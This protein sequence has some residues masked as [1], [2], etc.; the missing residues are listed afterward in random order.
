[1]VLPANGAHGSVEGTFKAPENLWESIPC[2]LDSKADSTF[3]LADAVRL[4][5]DDLSRVS[6]SL[7][8]PTSLPSQ[9]ID[10]RISE[11]EKQQLEENIV[12]IE[13]ELNTL[14]DYLKLCDI[15]RREA[16]NKLLDLK[17]SIRVFCRLRPFHGNEKRARPGP[18][19]APQSDQVVVKA[20]GKL[21]AY[22]FDKVFLPEDSQDDVFAELVPILRSALDGHNVCIF[23]YGQTGTGK[24]YTME[25][26]PDSPGVVPHTFKELFRQAALDSSLTFT[27][28]ISMLEV[29]KGSL[30]DLLVR[31]PTRPT[32]TSA[33]CLSIQMDAPSG[34]EI[35][36][37]HEVVVMDFKQA[38]QLYRL[39]RRARST[40]WTN[41]NEASSR[42]HSLIRIVIRGSRA[43][44]AYTI[45]SKL[46]MVDLGGSERILKTRASGQTMEEA[47]AINLSLSALGDVINALQRKQPHIPYRNSKLTQILK[48]SLAN[49]S[50]VVMLL[51]ISPR[52]D[53]LSETVCS[54]SFGTRARGTQLG[55]EL[56]AEAKEQRT[57][58]MAD[59]MLHMR[60]L[61]DECHR[62]I[63]HIQ[64]VELLLREKKKVLKS[65][66]SENQMTQT[67]ASQEQ[68]AIDTESADSCSIV[69]RSIELNMPRFM[70]PTACSRL[71]GRAQD[72]NCIFPGKEIKREER[73]GRRLSLP[74]DARAMPTC[75]KAS[76]IRQSQRNSDFN[77]NKTLKYSMANNKVVAVLVSKQG[78]IDESE[79]VSEFRVKDDHGLRCP[80]MPQRLKVSAGPLSKQLC[81]TDESQHL[82]MDINNG[83]KH[84]TV[85]KKR[86]FSESYSKK[87]TI[88][89]IQCLSEPNAT[90]GLRCTLSTNNK[91]DTGS[92]SKQFTTDE[93]SQSISES[94]SPECT[95]SDQVSSPLPN[96]KKQASFRK[97]I[98]SYKH[99][100]NTNSLE[101][102]HRSTQ[103]SGLSPG[104]ASPRIT[105]ASPRAE[106][107][108][109]EATY[110]PMLVKV[111]TWK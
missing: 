68:Y 103:N 64:T 30:R 17:G 88:D 100:I 32:E 46:W 69:D 110:H 14:K 96:T 60:H 42:S 33:K 28:T 38:F 87:F 86:R 29:Y 10:R 3:T 76:S 9:N 78:T 106:S 12:K 99:S 98:L 80:S 39:G 62:A 45:T 13:G 8:F 44:D 20:G 81:T 36:N 109:G 105:R 89:D 41:V 26:R 85:P 97:R 24:T 25:G 15:K 67:S 22:H 47:K 70:S 23:A 43:D 63:K 59:I 84:A 48:D 52:E 61:E 56:S 79:C 54:L 75:S 91:R 5:I 57:S 102:G 83:M 73:N 58:A 21:K 37:L 107:K 4:M 108:N 104:N 51:H 49:D 72:M 90:H 18:I 55:R 74:I 1:M 11:S 77:Y 94:Y 65:D 71:R 16:L 92:L 34:V 31:R 40:A 35:E 95:D 93:I 27:F 66:P 53:D 6:K 2:L 82:D 50:K 111:E 101:N 7:Q 19:V